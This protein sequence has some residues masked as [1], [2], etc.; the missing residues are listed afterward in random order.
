[1]G[2]QGVQIFT[3]LVDEVANFIQDTSTSRK[4]RIKEALNRSYQ[5]AVDAHDWPQLLRVS[6]MGHRFELDATGA[7]AHTFMSGDGHAPLPIDCMHVYG[8]VANDSTAT[9]SDATAS[10]GPGV[11]MHQMS[12]TMFHGEF[13]YGGVTATSATSFDES[14]STTRTP[15]YWCFS[16]T[17]AQYL[18][19]ATSTDEQNFKFS[20]SHANAN[21][22]ARFYFRRPNLAGET[23]W[24]DVT[25]A[26]WTSEFA[27]SGT[28]SEEGYPIT[29]IVVPSGWQGTLVAKTNDD[30]VV[31]SWEDPEGGIAANTTGPFVIQ[32]PLIKVWPVPSGFDVRATIIYKR[33]PLSLTE[34]EDTIEIPV[35]N[36]IVEKSI[37]HIF[38]QMRRHGTATQHDMIAMEALQTAIAA[39]VSP[40]EEQ[41]R[42]AVLGSGIGAAAAKAPGQ[43]MAAQ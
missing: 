16:G 25:A 6:D 1:M 14:L 31:V 29:R 33:Q 30:V 18:P 7:T 22:V 2:S 35:H 5:L 17:T 19:V 34:D 32:A 11:L 36:F 26:D 4:A 15:R 12:P 23:S 8:I 40:L 27:F 43:G 39:N 37:A 3:N 42:M 10:P 38:R 21:K 9:S 24:A 20:S 28:E 41:D 13:G